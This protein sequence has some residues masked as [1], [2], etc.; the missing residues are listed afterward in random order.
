MTEP[1]SVRYQQEPSSSTKILQVGSGDSSEPIRSRPAV[2]TVLVP[3]GQPRILLGTR[4]EQEE[5][6]KGETEL[7][8]QGK[9]GDDLVITCISD[10]GRPAGAV[11]A[12]TTAE[13][14]S[15][16]ELSWRDEAGHLVLTDTDT[17]THKMGEKSWRTVSVIRLRLGWE[18]RDRQ[19]YCHVTSY[20]SVEPLQ[21]NK[22]NNT[23]KN[24]FT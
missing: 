16:G 10:G 14:L 11:Q 13:I 15:R 2:V 20:V 12:A 21:V 3:P 23:R 22:L 8:I 5:W 18:D 17:S 24:L 6:T 1:T 7:E 9:E 19:I 4:E